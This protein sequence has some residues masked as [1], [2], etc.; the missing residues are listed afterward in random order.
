MTLDGEAPSKRIAIIGAGSSGIAAL[1]LAVDELDGW[2]IVCFEKHSAAVGAWGNPYSGFVST[3]TKYT[4]QFACHRRFD[5]SAAPPGVED[6]RE[7]F[8][9]GEYGQ[10]LKGLVEEQGLGAYIE[11]HA[12]VHRMTK[13][14]DGWTLS[15]EGASSRNEVFDR[16]IIC[17]GLAETPKTIDAP[18]ETL[19]A[20]DESDPVQG[21]TIVVIGGGESAVDIADRLARPGLR[22]RVYLSLK[23]GIRVSPRYHPIRGVP[24]DFLRTRLMLSIHEDIRNAIGQKFVEARIKHQGLFE[25]LSRSG[26]NTQEV[27]RA[28]R[29]R[30]KFWAAKLTERAKD[31]LFNMFHNKSD[32]FLDAVAEDR[33]RIIGPAVDD[34]YRRYADFDGEGTL[35]LD[36]DLVVPMIGYTSNLALLSGGT[37]RAADFYLGCLHVEHDDLFLVGFGRPIIG[38]IPP[39]SEAQARY[40]IGLIA[41]TYKRPHDIARAHAN[42]RRTLVRQYSALDTDSVYPVEMI[43]YCDDLARRM[44][45]YPSLRRLRSPR[46]WL[47]SMLTP[48][49]TL[50]YVNDDFDPDFIQR[51][52]VHSPLLIVALLLLVKVFDLPYRL[53]RWGLRDGP[54]GSMAG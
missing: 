25:Q 49:S 46:L 31:D 30:K 28:V 38:S 33:L 19:L 17:T 51:Q 40:V 52:R 12:S 4:T 23:G 34:S 22:N 21:K 41:G 27:S 48:A 18:V 14:S 3:S 43:P 35:Q 47:K 29:D 9:D 42:E 50:H 11:E 1:K 16:V 24:S 26:R 37:I 10:Y 5:A 13:G 39:I 32:G 53:V 45:S 36:P 20:I 7:F 54:P 8:K 15:I 2:E 6:G 44:G